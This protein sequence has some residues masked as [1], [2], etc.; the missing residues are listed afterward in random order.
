MSSKRLSNATARSVSKNLVESAE[1]SVVS[2]H[3]HNDQS[4][5]APG[6][7]LR[8]S[9]SA[10]NVLAPKQSLDDSHNLRGAHSTGKCQKWCS[11][12]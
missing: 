4:V 1:P 12:Y 3:N 6:K 2:S 11:V 5:E 9:L 8:G 7:S 10:G